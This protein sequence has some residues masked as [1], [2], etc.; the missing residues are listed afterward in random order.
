NWNASS[1][2]F[3]TTSSTGHITGSPAYGDN[4]AVW[5][6]EKGW[7]IEYN[8]STGTKKAFQISSTDNFTGCQPAMSFD[9]RR[10]YVCSLNGKFYAV[11]LA[12]GTNLSGTPYAIG[13]TNASVAAAP[14]PFID[15]LAS[16]PDGQQETVYAL[17]QTGTLYRFSVN[18]PFGAVQG[19]P[20]AG[21]VTMSQSYA[22]PRDNTA[23]YTEYFRAGPVVIDGKAVITSWRSNS[24][25]SAY[26]NGNCIYYDTGVRSYNPGNTTGMLLT[27]TTVSAPVWAPPS[28]EFDTTG[29]AATPVY[30]FFPTGHTATMVDLASTNST[31]SCPLLVDNTSRTS[32]AMFPLTYSLTKNTASISATS[33][34]CLSV[35]DSAAETGL[36]NGWKD[37]SNLEGCAAYSGDDPT[38][39]YGYVQFT[40]QPSD[41][42]N[43]TGGYYPIVASSVDLRCSSGSNTKGNLNTDPL[44][45]FEVSNNLSTGGAWTNTTVTPANRPTFPDGNAFNLANSTNE[46]A[47]ATFSLQG[48]SY[49]KNSTYSWAADALV[50]AVGTYSFGLVH[51]ELPYVN[52]SAKKGQPFKDSAPYFNAGTSPTLTLY[53]SSKSLSTP[54]MTTPLTIDS[55]N[56]RVYAVNTNTLYLLSYA[57]ATYDSA[58]DPFVAASLSERLASFSSVFGT[59]F[60]MTSLGQNSSAGPVSGSTYVANLCAPMLSTNGDIYVLDNHPTY[61]HVTLNRFTPP[62]SSGSAPAL[63]A[64]IDL[65]STAADA[66]AP[67]AMMVINDTGKYLY[68]GTYDTAAGNNTGRAWILTQL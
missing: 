8:T 50:N 52:T 55:L 20:N 34:A 30:A 25:N 11:D 59:Y 58:S 9:C 40:I 36:P 2:N 22:I 17:T 42:S 14:P 3:A 24:T 54:T 10:L 68:A 57:S 33:S 45:V 51:P 67:A 37:L 53:L 28:V 1:V 6:T 4:L 18:D 62:A 7:V 16:R 49:K 26:D 5:L 65:T 66:M 27:K 44:E 12:T 47:Y 60:C 46:S 48:S 32:G 39:I 43:G 41:L 63:A 19:A 35:A 23:P 13:G 61:N 21:T 29:G 56:K 31:Q 15:P 64:S 38:P